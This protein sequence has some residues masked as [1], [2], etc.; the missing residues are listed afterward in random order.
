MNQLH[1]VNLSFI[2][3]TNKEKQFK[4]EKQENYR[5]QIIRLKGEKIVN[6][7]ESTIYLQICVKDVNN[8]EISSNQFGRK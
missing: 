4:I 7:Y 5:T 1:I 3:E 2:K 6:L 8:V